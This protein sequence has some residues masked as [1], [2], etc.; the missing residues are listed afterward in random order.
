[1]IANLEGTTGLCLRTCLSQDPTTL[2][3]NKCLGRRD[4]ACQSEAYLGLAMYSGNRQRGWCTPQC[5]SDEDC[6]GRRCDLARGICVDTV[7]PGL[8]IGAK[9][10]ESLDC[11]G[12]LCIPLAGGESFCSAPCVFGQ[13]LGCG[14]GR[15]GARTAGCVAAQVVGFVSTEGIGDVGFCAELCGQTSD[16]EQAATANWQCEPSADILQSF[17]AAGVCDAPELGDGGVD[18][19]SEDASTPPVVG[20]AG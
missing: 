3:E 4:V 8:P 9:C 12:R 1:V 16:C 15:S 20:D 5:G 6:P 10:A 17:S 2:S 19:G 7:T 18:G 13:R 11:A 14:D